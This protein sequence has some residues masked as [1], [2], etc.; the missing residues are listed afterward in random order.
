M[1]GL[2]DSVLFASSGELL[3]RSMIGSRGAEYIGSVNICGAIVNA[4]FR[5]R[6]LSSPTANF[7]TVGSENPR[8]V[9]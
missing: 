6:S 1:D 3:N 9:S 4:S 2:Q 7:I 5:T 8:I